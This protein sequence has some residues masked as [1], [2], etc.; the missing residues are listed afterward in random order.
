MTHNLPDRNNEKRTLS[1]WFLTDGGFDESVPKTW[2]YFSERKKKTFPPFEGVVPEADIL[3]FKNNGG[4]WRYQLL[5]QR[6]VL[7]FAGLCP[8]GVPVP[9]TSWGEYSFLFSLFLC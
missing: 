8:E 3:K 1:G 6:N 5:L 9:T 7:G 4:P 2:N